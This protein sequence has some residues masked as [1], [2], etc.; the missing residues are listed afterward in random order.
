[1]NEFFFLLTALSKNIDKAY[2]AAGEDSSPDESSESSKFT[3][4]SVSS[5][6]RA[7]IRFFFPRQDN[8]ADISV[9]FRGY[10]Y[11]RGAPSVTTSW[12]VLRLLIKKTAPDVEGKQPFA[13]KNVLQS[14][15]GRKFTVFVTMSLDLK[16][17]N[18]IIQ[19][20]YSCWTTYSTSKYSNILFCQITIRKWTEKYLEGMFWTKCKR[21]WAGWEETGWEM[22]G[23]LYKRPLFSMLH[24][25]FHYYLWNFHFDHCLIFLEVSAD[26][27]S[28]LTGNY[29][30]CKTI[31]H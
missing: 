19:Q 4:F 25:R 13:G 9:R 7:C 6:I 23:F 31:L 18:V 14:L 1:M 3:I 12:L 22:T 17:I 2:V 20:Y 11:E 15:E 24:L 28:F 30:F 29:C 5:E 27:I 21:L 26:V 16:F 8:H 10:P